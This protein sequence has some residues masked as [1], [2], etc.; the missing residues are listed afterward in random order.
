MRKN[1]T[2]YKKNN[3]Q[4]SCYPETKKISKNKL[5]FQNLIIS[6]SIKLIGL[7]SKKF[8]Q[9]IT[10]ILGQ[11][12][13]FWE[14]DSSYL[15]L[16]TS[17]THSTYEW[18]NQNTPNKKFHPNFIFDLLSFFEKKTNNSQYIYF[19]N[20]DTLP[21]SA[22]TQKNFMQKEKLNSLLVYPLIAKKK[23]IG[24]WFIGTTQPTKTWNKKAINSLKL[25]SKLFSNA[26]I[27]HNE[28]EQLR[29]IKDR[30]KLAIQNTNLG[31]WDWNIITGENVCNKQWANMLGYKLN[32]IKMTLNFWTSLIHPDDKQRTNKLI[33]DYLKG[34]SKTYE[35]EFRL[36]TKD[37]KWKWILG[38][39]K[40]VKRDKNGKPI[41]MIGIHYDITSRKQQE[42]ALRLSEEKFFKAFHLSSSLMAITTLKDIFFVDVNQQ[43]CKTFGIKREKIIGHKL[44]K[45]NL[46][47]PK[48]E[49]QEILKFV[50]EGKKIIDFE[51]SFITPSGKEY[52]VLFNTEVIEINY[53][54]Y[55]LSIIHDITDRIKIK[56]QLEYN[57]YHDT[58]T[59]LPNRKLFI[60][61]LEQAIARAQR[62][63]SYLFAILFL[64]LDKFKEINDS[65]GHLAGDE[66]L[67]EVSKRLRVCIRSN[68]TIARLAGDEFTLLLDSIENINSAIQVSER[69]HEEF[70]KPFLLQGHKTTISGSIGV[71]L[72]SSHYTTADE[73][74]RDADIAMYRAKSSG[75]SCYQIFDKTMHQQAME[76]FN[77]K[78]DI[79]QALKKNQ[80]EILYQ[81]I[82]SINNE[83]IT[84][85]E[86]LLRW[87]HPK[88]GLL[89]P[90]KFISLAEDT[91]NIIEITEWLLKN[92]IAQVSQWHKQKHLLKLAVN[93]SPLNLIHS[94]FPLKIN[95][96]LKKNNLL[97]DFINLEI[98]E[99]NIIKN[100]DLNV[101]ALH[102]INDTC[103][104]I[105]I[106]KF[107]LGQTSLFQLN[108]FPVAA[109][110]I[111]KSFITNIPYSPDATTVTK[112]IIAMAK[113]LKINVIAGGV[114]NISQLEFLRSQNCTEFQGY[115]FSKPTSVKKITD[116]L[117]KQT[118]SLSK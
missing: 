75:R 20:L 12:G 109:L 83:T 92:A 71:L 86:A 57:V 113:A 67:V 117:K 37:N 28:E 99:N 96:I 14:I 46:H 87:N 2:T 18:C 114:E 72:F 9:E 77:L 33:N 4:K 103:G 101:T 36:K 93:L 3:T 17:K 34:K 40:V 26:I 90:E 56:Q 27:K 89:L 6:I 115:L 73:M 25:I 78:N 98:T 53:K 21:S 112:A 24:F 35:A 42:T 63:K 95:Q 88:K 11:I 111:D 94:N 32:E 66:F 106:D 105:A 38:I 80:I 65:L 85:V 10:K 74:L 84:G 31:L 69:I 59:K 16:L 61:N 100:F 19:P 51:V 29:F 58:L 41:R 97:S 76:L 54:K 13:N 81:P 82:V 116:L 49:H 68:D 118:C 47:I 23:P 7:N 1:T 108:K 30:F 43:F 55:L 107:G 104:N 62:D 45:L 5:K 91:G 70:A 64:D 22:I 39:G 52:F 15:F 102:K 8:G 110:K 50:A 60:H 48:K 79:R 44:A